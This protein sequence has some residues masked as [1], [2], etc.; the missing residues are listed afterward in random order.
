[1]RLRRICSTV[2]EFKI[3]AATLQSR[4]LRRG[5]TRS[6]LKEAY[7]RA[8]GLNREQL[9]YKTNITNQSD[10]D[11]NT[12]DSTR[13][14]LT[15]S[16]QHHSIRAIVN[17]YWFLLTEDPILSKYVSPRPAITYC[18]AKSLKDSLVQSHFIDHNHSV[19][20][21]QAITNL[22]AAVTPVNI[23]THVKKPH[24]QQALNG[25]LNI[26]SLVPQWGLSICYSAFVA[27]FMWGK[28]EDFFLSA[29]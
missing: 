10:I 3:Q 8:L 6:L 17:K 22:V 18:R 26:L 21:Q 9:L 25:T 13:C 16:S 15:F 11:T 4:F 20:V 2:E 28:P 5:Y 19:D 29:L 7:H 24:Y 1:M 14:V 27:H 23:S 12:L